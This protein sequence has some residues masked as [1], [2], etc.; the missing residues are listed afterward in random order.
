MGWL[1]ASSSENHMINIHSHDHFSCPLLPLLNSSHSNTYIS[2]VSPEFH[3]SSIFHPLCPD[4]PFLLCYWR[5]YLSRY[6]SKCFYLFKYTHNHY[7]LSC[8]IHSNHIST[9]TLTHSTHANTL[10]SLT[11]ITEQ[12][13]QSSQANKGASAQ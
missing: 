11:A 1:A 7:F 9:F 13:F 5:L 3:S 4:T 2:S 6:L 10:L 12:P 8:C